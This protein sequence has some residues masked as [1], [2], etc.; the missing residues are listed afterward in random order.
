MF[1][2]LD[3]QHFYETHHV[4]TKLNIA[5]LALDNWMRCNMALEIL[6]T[7]I[8]DE[9]EGRR[10]NVNISNIVGSSIGVF[11]SALAL[12]GGIAAPFTAGV[13]LGLTVTGAVIGSLSSVTVVGANI[14]ET[15]LNKDANEKFERYF[16]NISEH[17]R[18]MVRTF[19][20]LEKEIE[21]IELTDTDEIDTAKLQTA[22]GALHMIGGVPVVIARIILRAASLVDTIL[23]PLS[24]IIDFGVLGY[25]IFNLVKGSK[26]NVT[27]KLRSQRTF[28]RASRT[29]LMIYA[30]GNKKTYLK[31]VDFARA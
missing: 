30:Y 28:L 25:N 9:L 20:D 21:K 2:S 22:A 11:G 19:E 29:Q 3:F 12:A 31:A 4:K 14:T 10:R 6:C 27:E 5:K 13:S 26:T 16:M 23:P 7:D 1:F 18:I 15:V 8:I 24:A 17:S